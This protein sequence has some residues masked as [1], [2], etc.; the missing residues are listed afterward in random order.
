MN[1]IRVAIFGYNKHEIEKDVIDFGFELVEENPEVVISYG[2]DGTLILSEFHYPSVPKLLLKSSKICKLC[3]AIPNEEIL[4]KFKEGKYDVKKL[5]KLDVE[6]HGKKLKAVNDVIV[7]N[8]DPRHAMRYHVNI[9]GI[10][11]PSH[12]VIGDGVIVATQFGSTGYYKSITGSTF[13]VG[14][15]IAFN[16]STEQVNHMVI[17]EESEIKIKVTRGPVVVY[18]DNQEEFI[19]LEEGDEVIIR[20]SEE[21][22]ELVRI[23]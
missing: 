13:D 5:I 9:N 12:E 21:F 23:L 2:G 19:K 20:K 4:K 10:N 11:N 7:H 22:S 14:I 3:Q 15:G 16:N 18:A 8:S 1:K 6:A 17:D